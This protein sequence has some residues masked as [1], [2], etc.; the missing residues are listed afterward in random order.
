M[1]YVYLSELVILM[2]NYLI[3][4]AEHVRACDYRVEYRR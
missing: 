4:A 2:E 3:T 1:E